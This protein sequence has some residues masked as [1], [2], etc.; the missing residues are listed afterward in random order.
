MSPMRQDLSATGPPFAPQCRL[1]FLSRQPTQAGGAFGSLCRKQES[2]AGFLT[3]FSDGSGPAYSSDSNAAEPL[4]PQVRP[5]IR[6]GCVGQDEFEFQSDH[7]RARLSTLCMYT[8][9]SAWPVRYDD[10]PGSIEAGKLAKPRG[11]RRGSD[12]GAYR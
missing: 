11:L 2:H 7:S 5:R 3:G 10:K 1:M 6:G 8:L 4:S 12:A 9:N